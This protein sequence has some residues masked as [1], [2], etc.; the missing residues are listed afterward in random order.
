MAQRPAFSILVCPDPELLKQEISRLLASA[1]QK[2]WE[3][4]VFWGDEE[5]D[6]K[7]WESLGQQ[8]LFAAPRA[9]IVRNAQDWPASVWQRI[10]RSLARGSSDTWPIFCLEVGTEKGKFKVPAHIQKLPCYQFAEKQKWL[11]QK[12]QLASSTLEKYVTQEARS[13]RLTWAKGAFE[14]FCSSVRP[15]A[16][17]IHNELARLALVSPNG[18]IT[19]DMVS[20]GVGNPEANA[21]AIIRKIQAGDLPGSWKELANSAE[22]SLL[23]FLIALLE[24]DLRQIWA[25]VA[26]NQVWIPPA[27]APR[28]RE[29]A[30]KLGHAGVTAA[31]CALADAEWQVKSGSRTPEQALEWLVTELTLRFAESS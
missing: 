6:G 12:P 22:S 2:K 31:L 9:V 23:F 16:Q 20:S 27:D 17:L 24:R 15:E 10:S 1:G 4:S 8:S 11:W 7:F 18:E 5:P 28:K 25:L 3:K 14:Q 13:Q 21:F 26:G 19:C 30:R 29:L